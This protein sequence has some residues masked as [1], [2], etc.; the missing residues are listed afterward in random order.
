MVAYDHLNICVAYTYS[1]SSACNTWLPLCHIF[2]DLNLNNKPEA[3]P[4]PELEL[5]TCRFLWGA[6]AKLAHEQG[7]LTPQTDPAKDASIR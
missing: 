4:G 6:A 7:L 2:S 1:A 5:V 3:K